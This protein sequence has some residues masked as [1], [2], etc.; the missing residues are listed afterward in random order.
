MNKTILSAVICAATFFIVNSQNMNNPKTNTSLAPVEQL[1]LTQKWDKTFLKSDKVDH[2][3]VT[4]VNRYGITLAADMYKPKGATGKL[5][6]IAVCGP[7][8]AVKEQAAGF[9]AQEMAERGFLTIAFDPSFTGESGGTPRYM[10]SPD[11][12]TE[13]FSAAV[14]YLVTNPEVDSDKVGII[15]ICGWGGIAIN[16]AASDPRIKATLASTMYDMSR[17]NANGYF[18]SEDSVEA[19]NALREKLAT[20]RTE[21]Y[22][23]GTPKLGGGVPDVLPD[24]APKFLRDYYDYYKTK[25]GYHPRSLNS[26]GGRNAT[27]PIPWINFP[28]MSRAGEIENAVMILHGEKAHSF[29]FG[30]GAYKKLTVA[31]GKENNKLFLVIPGASHTDLY[32]NMK[33]IPFDGIELFFKEYLK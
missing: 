14:D 20:Q 29:Y 27:S 13:D 15:G 26:N 4:F 32:D 33:V 5:P 28:L 31:P 19:R 21:D 23:N 7:F 17:V 12:N 10:T 16:A 6:A 1:Q 25:R 24:D 8:G 30:S 22:I 18:D 2:S 11:I 3:K 9:Y